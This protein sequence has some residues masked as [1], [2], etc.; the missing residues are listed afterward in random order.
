MPSVS[1]YDPSLHTVTHTLVSLRYC[2]VGQVVQVSAL[3]EHVL[4]F[5]SHLPQLSPS[6]ATKYP[7]LH[8]ARLMHTLDVIGPEQ[9]TPV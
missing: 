5:P 9:R 2:P 3:P 4:Q 8:A 6:D 7:A 1:P